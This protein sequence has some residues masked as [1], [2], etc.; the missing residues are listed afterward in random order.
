MSSFRSFIKKFAS[1]EV[2]VGFGLAGGLRWSSGSF[3]GD[4]GA[5]PTTWVVGEGQGVD[6]VEVWGVWGGLGLVL[7]MDGREAQAFLDAF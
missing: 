4:F 1:F 2:L 7:I 3:V 5:R 6:R